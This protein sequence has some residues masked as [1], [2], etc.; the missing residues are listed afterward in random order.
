MKSNE[1]TEHQRERK[2][3]HKV[4]D[5]RVHDGIAAATATAAAAV[6][7]HRTVRFAS[8]TASSPNTTTHL[9][10]MVS[11]GWH[12]D[13]STKPAHPPAT[14]W[15][16][17]LCFLGLLLAVAVVVEAPCCGC[18]WLLMLASTRIG[19]REQDVVGG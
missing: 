11:R 4:S 8:C 17:G 5:F 7:V 2:N 14:R 19:G 16:N 6:V 12:T 9:V 18:C 10:L 3:T 13:D 15:K 1:G